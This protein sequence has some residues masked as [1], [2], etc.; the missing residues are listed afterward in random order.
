MAEDINQNPVQTEPTT[1]T[2]NGQTQPEGKL[3][4]QAEIDTIVARRVARATRGMPSEEELNAFHDWQRSNN[5]T[6]ISNL[7]NERDTARNDLLSAK[8]ELEALKREKVLL[9]KGIDKDDIEYYAFKIGKMVDD[10]TTFEQATDAFLSN[11]APKSK[12]TV[13]LSANLDGANKPNNSNNIMNN[14]IRGVK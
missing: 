6:V 4:T 9:A 2:N 10:K 7:T 3:M 8:A 1:E 13:D 5:D 14:L 12:V 11:N